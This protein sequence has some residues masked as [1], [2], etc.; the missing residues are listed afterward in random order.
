[1]QMSRAEN[2]SNELLVIGYGNTLRGDDGVGVRVVE[3]LEAMKLPGL[4]CITCHQL[5]PEIAQP[6]SEC[7]EV[8]F[9]DAAAEPIPDVELRNLEPAPTSQIMAHAADPKTLLTLA[10]DVFG[11][12][13]SAFWLMIPTQRMELGETLSALAEGGMKKAIARISGKAVNRIHSFVARN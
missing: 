8:I 7:A 10:R 6:I 13:P 11:H 12:C 2:K 4:R 3:A 1:M 5:T 9:V